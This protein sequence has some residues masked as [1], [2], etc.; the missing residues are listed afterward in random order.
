LPEL[1]FTI[2]EALS[3]LVITPPKKEK[4]RRKKEKQIINNHTQEGIGH[5]KL[6]AYMVFA[7]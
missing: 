6:K 4:L 3:C 7:R 5:T 2:V 1:T